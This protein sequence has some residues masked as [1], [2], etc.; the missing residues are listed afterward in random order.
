MAASTTKIPKTIVE[1]LLYAHFGGETDD[2]GEDNQHNLIFMLKTS[3]LE[4]V[5]GVLRP[6]VVVSPEKFCVKEKT[7][8]EAVSKLEELMNATLS[9]DRNPIVIDYINEVLKRKKTI[10]TIT[11]NKETF[12]ARLQSQSAVVTGLCDTRTITSTHIIS[13]NGSLRTDVRASLIKGNCKY[14]IYSSMHVYTLSRMIIDS[15][16]SQILAERGTS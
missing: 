1:G 9:Q 14:T 12:S 15:T 2:I 7:F 8:M 6:F 11:K 10:N 5:I 13:T 4:K 3:E 16:V